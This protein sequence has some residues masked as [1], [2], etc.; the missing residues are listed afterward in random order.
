MQRVTWKAV[1]VCKYDIFE[2][3]QS[4]DAELG[5]TVPN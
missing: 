4:I 5:V 2:D 3:Q 1:L